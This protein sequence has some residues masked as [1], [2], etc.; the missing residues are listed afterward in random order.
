MDTFQGGLLTIQKLRSGN[1]QTVTVQHI[2]IT[3]GQ[4]VVAGTMQ[5]GAIQKPEG[6]EVKNEG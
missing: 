2:S 1:N 4:T 3:G 6:P 5:T